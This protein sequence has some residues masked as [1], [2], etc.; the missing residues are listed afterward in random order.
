VKIGIL[1]HRQNLTMRM[2]M[3]RFTRLINAFSKKVET[4]P[5]PSR[6]TSAGVTDHVWTLDALIGLLDAAERVPVL[7]GSYRQTRERREA[8]RRVLD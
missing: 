5:P 1:R 4:S 2:S 6:S 8:A 3:L 7:R